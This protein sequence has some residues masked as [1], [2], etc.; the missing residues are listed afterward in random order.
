MI[1]LSE[2][3][4]AELRAQ[5]TELK[6]K[7]A[8]MQAIDE[9]REVE[10]RSLELEVAV[11]AQYIDRLESIEEEVIA[12]KEIHIRNLEAIIDDLRRSASMDVKTANPKLS[13]VSRIA[14][15]RRRRD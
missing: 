4:L 5:V 8:S 9:V 1:S 12:P 15:L 11:K 2:D 14:G 7:I 10:L 3:E 6:S 13:P